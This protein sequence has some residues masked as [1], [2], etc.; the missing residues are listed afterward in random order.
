MAQTDLW[1]RASQRSIPIWLIVIAVV[2][3]GARIASKQIAEEP[4]LVKWVPIEQ[5]RARANADNKPIL[6]DFTAAWC[7]PCRT[8][9]HE[10]FDDPVLAKRINEEF[11][12][13]R[14]VDRQREDGE[15]APS[16]QELQHRYSVGA[17][18]TVVLADASGEP[19]AKMEG[20]RG[21]EAFVELMERVP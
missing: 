20:F 18:P 10:V 8:L 4:S 11:V 14:V 5:A 12:P 9:E 17:F 2:V 13:V 6:Y 19:H 15:N 16:V 7:G 3:F 1:S 21:R